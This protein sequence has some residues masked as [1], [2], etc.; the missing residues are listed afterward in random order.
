MRQQFCDLYGKISPESK[1]YVLRNIY[2]HLT[3]NASSSR[4]TAEAEIDAHITEA[5]LAEDAE[6]ILD[7][8]EI[9]TNDSDRFTTFWDKCNEFLQTCT[10]VHERRH[11]TVTFM[12]KLISIRDLIE[13]VHKMCTEGTPI[14]SNAL[15]QFNFFPHN[16]RTITAK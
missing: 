6:I 1:P 3:K 4:T 15:V 10:T 16:P 14:P 5:I 13:Q 12:A 9:N 7:L 8:L 2:N 11:G